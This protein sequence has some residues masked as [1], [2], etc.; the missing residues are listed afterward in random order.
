M[1]LV[2]LL[3][4]VAVFMGTSY[5]QADLDAKF[6]GSGRVRYEN[7]ENRDFNDAVQDRN[8]FTGVR[9]RLGV[10]LEGDEDTSVY[11]Q[12]QYTDTWGSNSG[13]L[14]LNTMSVYQAY[15]THKLSDNMELKLGRQAMAYG[16]HLIVGTVGWSNVGRSF[17]AAKLKYKHSLG[18]VDVFSAEVGSTSVFPPTSVRNNFSGI[19]AAFTKFEFIDALDFYAFR[20]VKLNG[21]DDIIH[22]GLRAK[23]KMGML[24]YRFEGTAQTKVTAN[25]M[26]LEVG[27]TLSEDSKMRVAVEAF[28]ASKD[29]YQLY[30][31]AHKW[32]GLADVLFRRNLNGLRLGFQMQATE[33][34]NVKADYHMFMRNDDAVAVGWGAGSLGTVGTDKNIGSELDLV[35]NYKLGEKIGLLAGGS[36]F[37]AGDYLKANGRPDDQIWFFTQVATKF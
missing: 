9:Y 2:R 10:T 23:S 31:T 4:L 36:Y 35:F 5:A 37:M 19:Y 11:I 32:L 34:L 8:S 7:R 21:V 15:L 20:S 26:D 3:S 6:D 27:Y 13:G 18:W 22:A 28:T 33:K 29:Y 24:D 17:D 12:T 30:P 14:S 16:D 1:K 25:Q